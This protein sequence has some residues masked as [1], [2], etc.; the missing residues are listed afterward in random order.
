MFS[1]LFHSFIKN[2]NE[3]KLVPIYITGG[4]VKWSS[5]FGKQFG[6]S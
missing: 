1:T 6:T 5:L 2:E 4:N 3:E